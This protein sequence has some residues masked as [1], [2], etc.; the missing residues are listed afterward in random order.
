MFSA[1]DLLKTSALSW[2]LP[3]SFL[4]SQQQSLDA[5]PAAKTDRFRRDKDILDLARLF[6]DDTVKFL[7]CRKQL[8][9][10]TCTSEPNIDAVEKR[11]SDLLRD[12]KDLQGK[13]AGLCNACT[14]SIGLE[15]KYN[16]YT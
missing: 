16:Q 9:W 6:I 2:K 8:N 1:S 12:F 13:A 5:D 15:M 7:V 4:H 14:A 11:V 3:F 10:P